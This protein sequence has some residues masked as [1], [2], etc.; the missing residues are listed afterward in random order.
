[1]ALPSGRVAWLITAH[2]QVRQVLASPHVSSDRGRDNFPIRFKQPDPEITEKF[3]E[4]RPSLI[5]VD[6][7]FHTRLRRS[8]I[9]EFTVRRTRELRPRVQEIVDGAVDDLLESGKDGRPVDLVAKVSLPVPSMVI[10]ELLGV[11][12]ADHDFFQDR[13]ATLISFK[14]APEDGLKAFHDLGDYFRDLVARKEKAPTDDLIGRLIVAGRENGDHDS[15]ELVGL[16]QLLLI[17]GHE[18]TANMIS[19]GTVALLEDPEQLR[20]LRE[21]P[22]TLMPKAVEELLRFFTIA[23]TVTARTATADIEVGG[24]TIRAGEGLIASGLAA[25]RDPH[26]Y[27]EPDSLDIT[28]NARNHVAFGYGVHQC[29]GQNLARLELDIVYRT[30]FGRVPG[31]TLAVPAESLSYKDEALVYGINEV[32]VTW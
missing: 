24:I 10:C 7:P 6:P 11:P 31:L 29:L 19:L 1:M 21:D 17:A 32:P 23:D 12:Y 15:E 9:T 13:T 8:V 3:K 22:D 5:G 30:L 20:A 28:R 18:T 25:N 26:A 27:P 2:D 16:A 4:F 14:R